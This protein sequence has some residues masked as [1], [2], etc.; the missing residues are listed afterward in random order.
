MGFSKPIQI[1]HIEYDTDIVFQSERLEDEHITLLVAGQI[2]T[3]K[4]QLDEITNQF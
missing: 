1:L 4:V 2:D 3:G